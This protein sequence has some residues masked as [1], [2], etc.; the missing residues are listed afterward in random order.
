MTPLRK[1]QVIVYRK[2]PG[3]E[4]L[5]LKTSPMRSQQIW[6]GVTGGVESSDADLKTAA[7]REL[8]EE[9][10]IN[11]RNDKLMGPLYSFTF[12]TNRKGYEGT[13]ATEY[14]FGY[15]VSSDYKVSLSDE[16]S[17]F[18]WL[19]YEQAVELIDY[20]NS[21]LVIRKIYQAIK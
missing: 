3:L 10:K 13:L 5:L 6:Q 7:L 19:S 2:E 9:L 4:F 12:T 16:H 21:K 14:C 15:E 11:P 18:K 17:E 20:E 1:V 8:N